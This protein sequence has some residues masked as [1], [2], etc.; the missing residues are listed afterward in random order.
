M[1]WKNHRLTTF[2][3][4]FALTGSFPAT[5]IATASSALPDVLEMKLLKHRA[6]TH[7]PW[8]PLVP[9]IFAWKS[10]QNEPSYILY[11][12]FF[13]LV[14]YI[15]HLAADFLGDSGIPVWAGKRIGMHLY[16]T[17]TKSENIVARV[18][19]VLA[20]FCIW[21]KGMITQSYLMQAADNTA[22]FVT[23]MVRHFSQV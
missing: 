22:L 13:I 23:G 21:D 19:L 10:M 3:V 12:F 8:L 20:L 17:H 6:L 7:Y 11:V 18:V 1:Q 16:V 9:A 2:A 5:A 14:G 4:T 15:G